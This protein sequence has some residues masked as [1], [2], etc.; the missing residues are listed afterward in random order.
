MNDPGRSFGPA[1]RRYDSVRPS[2]PRQAVAWALAPLGQGRWRVADVGAGSGIMS[3]L[4]TAAGHDVLAVEPDPLM[5]TRLVETSPAVTAVVGAA[6][7]LPLAA[8]GVDAAIAAQAYHWFDHDAAHA[9]LARVVRPGGTVA[10]IWNQR[11]ESTPWVAEYTRT[12]GRLDQ[13]YRVDSFGPGFGPVERA[14]F[15]HRTRHTPESLVRLMQSRSSYL[16]ATTARQ[17]ALQRE[18]LD[19]TRTHP[20]LAGRSEFELPYQT[21]VFRAVRQAP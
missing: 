3:R 16:Q 17:Q 12:V 15:S 1:A 19:L 13:G 8:A 21:L 2:Y 6:E 18:I 9:E 14:V 4:L 20:E 11:D 5:L 10:A 7:A